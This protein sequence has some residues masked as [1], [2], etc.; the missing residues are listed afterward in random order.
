MPKF[1]LN[2]QAIEAKDGQTIIQAA[3]DAGIDIPHYCYHPD[4]PIDGNCR[5]CL[6]D[7]EKMPKLTP[8]C[9][10][11]AT[12]GMVVRSDNERVK[13]AVRGVLEFLL[14]NH[15]VDCPVCDQA[16]ECRLQDYYM[17][18]GLHTS[19]IPLQMKVRKRKVIDL[20]S[21]VVLDQERCVLCSRCIRFFEEVTHTGEMQFFGRGDH[22]AIGTFE[23]RPLDNPYSGNVVDI[24]PVGALTSRDFRFKCRVWFL[25]STDSVCGGCST[26]CN[27]R[28]DHRDGTVFRLLPRRNVEV[29]RSWL[30]D[31]GRLSFHQV[32]EG[33]RVVRPMIKGRDGIQ[34]PVTWE[35]AVRSI[36][37]R[38]KEVREAS[39][40]GSILGFASPSATNEAL[41]LLKRYLGNQL[42]VKSFDFR[43]DSEDENIAEEED[44]I[45]RHFDKH[46]NSMGAMKLGLISAELG[47][48]QG[49]IKAAR[50]GKIK[51]GV[52]VYLKPLVRRP[53]D[54]EVEGRIFELIE[55]L[56]YSVV[57]AA[58]K[59]EWQASA[60]VLLPVAA[61][62]EED[63][64]YTNF[65]G[66]VQFAG[67]AI[68]PGGDALPVWEVFAMLLHASGAE[69]PW[70]SA[71]DVFSSMTAS[72]AAYR[73]LTID[74]TRLP[75]VIA[76]T[77]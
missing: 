2:D 60:S 34:A 65:Q 42:G 48:I 45:L 77:L 18:Y 44:Q 10:A 8:A 67:K 27:V 66:R 9:T 28:I 35:D 11:I 41:F 74:Q 63:G 64:T 33:E 26:G 61:W 75:G 57:L 16:G 68:E 14:I 23:D 71:Q 29:N 1:T 19:E 38:L 30:C 53:S 39:G 69:S 31:E 4:L 32:S 58:H 15:P 62:S 50:D 37:A 54:E 47:G 55:T 73:G 24:C 46:P 3:Q 13:E 6:V 56:E 49:A 40:A 72:E 51:A 76:V 5:M 12:E 25:H 52:V 22:V 59:A 17:V 20:G 43:V 36:D 70:M 7:V 21:M